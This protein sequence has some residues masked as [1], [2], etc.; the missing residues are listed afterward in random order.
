MKRLLTVLSIGLLALCHA[1]AARADALADKIRQA[2][3]ALMADPDAALRFSREAGGMAD[4]RA[5]D[6]GTRIARATAF[7][8]EAE[9]LLGLNRIVEA[10]PLAR[11]AKSLIEGA[12]PRAKVAGDIDRTLGAIAGMQGKVQEALAHHQ[13]AYRIYSAANDR[14]ARSIS[15][16]DIGQIYWD[17]GDYD[18]VLRYFAQAEE[19]MPR[20][21]ASLLLVLH[22]SRGEVL[23]TMG[24]PA[25][26][27]GE[28]A[29]ALGSARRLKSDMLVA[30]VL[31]NRAVAQIEAGSLALASRTIASAFQASRT[32]DVAEWRPFIH[33]AAAQLAEKRNALDTA[34]AEIGR[35]FAGQNLAATSM[36]YRE[37]HQV[38]AR[39]FERRGDQQLALTHLRAFQRLDKEAQAL[40]ATNSAQL[41]AAQFDFTNQNLR[42]AQLKQGQLERDIAIE[43]QRSRY[44]TNLFAGLLIAGAIV[45]GVAL[46][47]FFSVRRS[48][49]QVRAAN[50]E[51]AG[52]NVAL[53]KALKAKTEFLATTSH[54]IRTPLNGLRGMTQVLLTNRSV[55]GD[56]R[57][58]I[59]V[60]HGAG[61]T[62][63]ALVDDL[64]DV[65][66]LE[67]GDLTLV[68]ERVAIRDLI[69]RAVTLW[70]S[71]AEAKGL[72]VT[73]TL[74][75]LPAHLM[76]DAGRVRQIL[77]NLLSNAVKFTPDGSIEVSALV[78][79]DDTTPVLRMIV[80]DT[81]IGIDPA[82]RSK[83]FEAFSQVDGGMTRQ[84]S[85]TGLGLSIVHRLVD[86]FGGSISL[87]SA[88]GAGSTFTVDLP[89]RAVEADLDAAES[90]SL[91][92]RSI[93]LVD[94]DAESRQVAQSLLSG[95]GAALVAA[96]SIDDARRLFEASPADIVL[97]NARCM[98]DGEGTDAIRDLA[99]QVAGAGRRFAV[100]Q[101]ML[102]SPGI[103]ELMMLRVDQIIMQPV[104]DGQFVQ[105]VLTLVGDEPAAFVDAGWSSGRLAA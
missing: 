65:A 27:D 103:A 16:L 4:A 35:A 30:R 104:D 11:R 61:E 22:N 43:R 96:R 19:L 24:R 37:A 21:D 14:R 41:M 52:T 84:F 34:A 40:I 23:R 100:Q 7:R 13:S 50:T 77:F 66:K 56:V 51:L 29:K 44:R 2:E 95:R 80:R 72:A 57:E 42:I 49:N 68:E 76:T 20:D 88:L 85:G 71:Q 59:E 1:G 69:G 99:E 17:A 47:G 82:D 79:D 63:R 45:L 102:G 74:D 73:A 28:F 18:R 97:V 39:I 93:L 101:G 92:G 105:A 36:P 81:G 25:E 15:L 55:P 94:A 5:D 90:S 26:A 12:A 98:A 64:L 31:T 3:T 48:R 87:D 58:Q 38:A 6:R 62:M 70:R 86:R 78:V 91:E 33:T 53:E 9:A 75:G 89:V 54:E 67:H 8:L 46:Y 10:E 60:V 83:V 32:R